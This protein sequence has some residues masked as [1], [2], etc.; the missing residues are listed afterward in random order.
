MTELIM[1]AAFI[2]GVAVFWGVTGNKIRLKARSVKLNDEKFDTRKGPGKS[3]QDRIITLA[4]GVG[5]GGIA[6]AITGTWYFAVLGLCCGSLVLRW[7]KN[8][9]EEDRMDLLRSQFVD[10]LGQLESAL[11]GGM[12][13]YQALEDAVPNMPRPARDIFYEVIRRT[14]TGDTLAQAIETVRKE[15]GWEDLKSLSIGI[16]LYNRVGCNLGEICRHSMDSYE[17]KESFRG[18]VAAA[19]AQNM[20]TM[21]VLTG[22]PFA[23]VGLARIV[24]PGFAEPLFQTIEGAFVFFMAS[25]WIITGNI[26]TRRI[27]KNALGQG[28]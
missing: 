23:F 10:V 7:W 18:I 5:L 28:V 15:T 21:K 12:N 27:I 3:S 22:L 26:L 19:V 17:D 1:L 20:M 4:G 13:P 24:A 16:S 6:Y 8:K 25:V 2:M 9:Q 11:Y 14:R